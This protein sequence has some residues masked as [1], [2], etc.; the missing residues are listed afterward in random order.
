[1]QMCIRE[2]RQ[3]VEDANDLRLFGVTVGQDGG[4]EGVRGKHGLD[5]L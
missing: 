1:M 3:N 5:W 4:G 2:P